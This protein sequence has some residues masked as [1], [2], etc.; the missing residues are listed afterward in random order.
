M[1]NST[2]VS[3]FPLKLFSLEASSKS[4]EGLKNP[5]IL[6]DK[7]TKQQD[8]KFKSSFEMIFTY[9]KVESIRV[10][11]KGDLCDL[12]RNLNKPSFFSCKQ[13]NGEFKGKVTLY[14]KVIIVKNPT[15]V[16][17]EKSRQRVLK[18]NR[19]VHSY[20]RANF[21]SASDDISLVNF[22]GARACTY[23]PYFA[24]YF[25]DC[26]TKAEITNDEVKNYPFGV[27]FGSNV[28]LFNEYPSWAK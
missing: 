11:E 16:I 3:Q 7:N 5:V 14:A 10:T 17:S 8:Q 25:F 20:L 28:Y 15:F 21:D 23:N 12:Y 18:A 2:Q 27:L 19:N 22:D 1:I 24:G 26:E 4:K 6:K 13:R 9:K